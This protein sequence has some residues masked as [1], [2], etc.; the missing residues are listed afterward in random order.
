MAGK[1]DPKPPKRKRGGKTLEPIGDRPCQVC[2]HDGAG[3]ERAHLLRGSWK[4]DHPHLIA[5]LCG[6]FGRCRVHPRFDAGELDAVIDVARSLKP[7]QKRMMIDRRGYGWFIEKFGRHI[8][9]DAA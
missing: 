7:W 3:L 5:V 9:E 4:E 8:E 2:G 1:P 6:P